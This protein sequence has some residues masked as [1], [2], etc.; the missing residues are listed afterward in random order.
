MKSLNEAI[1]H[2]MDGDFDD[3][4]NVCLAQFL[5]VDQLR[6]IEISLR[7]PEF[8]VAKEWTRENILDQLRSDVDFG[9]EKALGQRSFEARSTAA[10]VQFWNWVLDEGLADF[11]EYTLYGLPIFKATAVKY[12]FD[13]PI[14][15]DTGSE[16]KYDNQ[17]Y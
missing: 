9:F 2:L 11:G 3:R 16:T 12:G 5:L 14:G 8:H 1:A 7:R 4:S 17:R 13:N 10:V 6:Q 15:D